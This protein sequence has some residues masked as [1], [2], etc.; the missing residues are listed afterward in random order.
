M[1][2][3][4]APNY[5]RL[6]VNIDHIAT[7][8]N[9]RGGLHPDP[10]AGAWTAIQAGADGITAHLREDRRHILDDDLERLQTLCIDSKIPLN[11]EMA[12]TDEM[13]SIAAKLK[14]HAVCLVPERREERTT[15]GGLNVIG[16][17]NRI[18]S[19]ISH[20]TERGSR[21][22][23]FIEAVPEQIEMAARTG[24]PV[25]E[26]HAGAY[27][28]ALDDEDHD[29]ATRILKQLEE[30]AKLAA[31]L[32]LEVHAGHGLTFDNVYDIAA[33]PEVKELNIG[34]FIMGEGLFIGLD[35]AIRRMREIMDDARSTDIVA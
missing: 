31:D 23:L 5:L 16:N 8:R 19:L 35:P 9:A 30:G 3:K 7:L 29:K 18:T 28:H 4:T 25:I 22:S 2:D 11:M 33:I 6:G 21:L 26:L 34:H 17:H 20:L 14:P 24:A 32:G 13:E 10:V 1:Q 12:V 27:A 15:E